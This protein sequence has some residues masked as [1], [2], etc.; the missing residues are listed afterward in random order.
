MSDLSREERQFRLV[1]RISAVVYLAVGL[2][3]VIAPEWILAV[4]NFL[5]V[6]LHAV[7]LP[8]NLIETNRFW[9]SLAFS[10]MMTITVLCYL[11]Q[12]N[13]RKAVG[14]VGALLTAKLASTL[15]ALAF[16]L[17][18]PHYFAY[19]VIVLM[20]GSIFLITLYFFLR[21][22]RIFFKVQTAYWRQAPVSP[23]ITPA[24]KVVVLTGKDKFEVLDRVLE[25]T[26]FF[27]ILER[28]FQ[29]SKVPREDFSVVI[30]P[31]FMFM[32][33]KKDRSSYTDPELV[34]ALIDKIVDRGFTKVSVVESQSTFGNYYEN[35]EV[36]N[37]ARYIGYTE[38][39]YR[40]VDLTV[41]KKDHPCGGRLGHHPVGPTWRD[42]HFR[43]S[44]AKNKTHSFSHYTLTI[45]NIYGT[46]PLQD[47]LKEYHTLREYDWPTIEIL[48]LFPVHFG[49]I[50]AFISADGP[51]GV[52]VCNAP[53]HTRTIIG[54]EN[55]I[56][57]DYVGAKKMRL[58]PCDPRVGRFLSLAVEALGR[59]KDIIWIGDKSFYEPWQNV[60]E[61][62]LQF[63]DLIEEAYD[64]ANWW[65]LV[66]TAMDS[67]FPLKQQSWGVYVMRKILAPVKRYYYLYDD[68]ED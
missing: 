60:N 3:L 11:A 14:Y 26:E 51:F 68:L 25:Q 29:E 62:L 7:T 54:G 44:F 5:A 2:A 61:P 37:V 9:L 41:E 56:A 12:R 36:L 47:K 10:M 6:K 49:L 24:T 40:L 23:P 64:F 8:D 50:D 19:L 65:F 39:N 42:A 16:T 38:K 4:I 35:R 13:V 46:L 27:K 1:L 20:D 48:K 63:L 18:P 17:F 15:S 34:E 55:L 33:A 28:T 45:K 31:N 21:A 57:V 30:K 43:I 58:D 52:I 32:H 22:N 53:K 59:P 66:L 67:H